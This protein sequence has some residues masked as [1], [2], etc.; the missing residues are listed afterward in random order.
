MISFLQMSLWAAVLTVLICI[1]RAVWGRRLP[2]RTF[3]ILWAVVIL[4][5]LVPLSLP[6]MKINIGIAV[7]SAND[8]AMVQDAV[9]YTY[10]DGEFTQTASADHIIPQTEYEVTETADR[11][12]SAA[13]I[14]LLTS[15]AVFAVFAAAHIRFRLKVRDAIPAEINFEAGLKRQVRIKVSDRIDSPLTYGIFRPVILLPKNIYKCDKKAAEYILSHEL[16]HIKRFD[17]LYKLFMVLAVSLHWFNPLAWVM[18]VLA[19]RDIELSCDEEVVLRKNS[20]GR[21]REEYA[22]TLIEMEEKRSFGVLQSGFGGSSVKERI[23]SVMQ[24]K[25][26]SPA[27]KAA[28]VLLVAMAFTVFTVYDIENE[29]FYSVTVSASNSAEAYYSDETAV[30]EASYSEYVVESFADTPFTMEEID[31]ALNAGEISVEDAPISFV[32]IGDSFYT[33][34]IA[35]EEAPVTLVETVAAEGIYETS[36]TMITRMYVITTADGT[37]VREYPE[38][39]SL[40]HFGYDDPKTG[41]I[42]TILVDMN[43]YAPVDYEI[44][45]LTVSEDKGYFLYNGTPVGGFQ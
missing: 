17:V 18:L 13:E 23:K 21:E 31:R 35:V 7:S 3:R 22:L 4:R 20:S 25:K 19:S 28:A 44:Y 43:E 11:S 38:D 45:G 1:V 36:D 27:G 39:Y 34:D 14:W 30:E 29:A 24:L 10:I 37:V 33:S 8:T 2:K 40:Y 26:A 6:V 12:L 9:A 15:A 16:T 32:E 41:K 5:M 42:A